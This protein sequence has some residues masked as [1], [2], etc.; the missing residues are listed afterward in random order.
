MNRNRPL[1]APLILLLTLPFLASLA[2]AQNGPPFGNGGPPGEPGSPTDWSPGD[3]APPWAGPPPHAGDDEDDDDTADNG[4]TDDGDNG[5]GNGPPPFCSSDTA[6]TGPSGQA[7]MSSIAH[8][9]FG[10]IDTETGDPVDEGAWARMM[11]RWRAPLFD[12]V[13]NGKELLPEEEYTLTYQPEPIPSS[14]VICLG[15]GTAN[16][17]G[18]LNIQDAFDIATDLPALHDQNDEEATLALVPSAHVD[19]ETGDMTEWA[20]EDYLFTEE[21]IIYV[22]TDLDTDLDPDDDDEEDDNGDDD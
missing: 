5:N 12:Y 14:G 21:G 11:Y 10:Q 2:L 20:P 4:D 9:N 3:G 17:G 19:C 8:V 7:G 1:L 13:F 15:F 6:P 22:D 18:N 16:S